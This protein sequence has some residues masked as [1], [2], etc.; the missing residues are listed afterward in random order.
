MM[1]PTR[2][3]HMIKT[4]TKEALDIRKMR[5]IKKLFDLEFI[6]IWN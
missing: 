1:D 3:L 6:N 2:L 5:Q 4:Y